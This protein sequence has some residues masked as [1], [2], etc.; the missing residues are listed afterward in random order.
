MRVGQAAPLGQ[1]LVCWFQLDG[2]G[3]TVQRGL[4]RAPVPAVRALL[5]FYL[6]KQI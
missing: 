2:D 4:R 3:L 1:N 5:L 6:H